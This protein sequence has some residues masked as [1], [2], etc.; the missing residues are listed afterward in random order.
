MTNQEHFFP[1]QFSFLPSPRAKNQLKDR[2]CYIFKCEGNKRYHQYQKVKYQC[3]HFDSRLLLPFVVDFNHPPQSARGMV[4]AR[5]GTHTTVI[6]RF[7]IELSLIRDS[8]CI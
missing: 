3:G 6:I 1:P 5:L 4:Q 8:P 7:L 2:M